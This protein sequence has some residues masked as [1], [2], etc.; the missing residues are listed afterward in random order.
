MLLERQVTPPVEVEGSIVNSVHDDGLP[1]EDGHTLPS[2]AYTGMVPP[3]TQAPAQRGG[4]AT[5]AINLS[6]KYMVPKNVLNIN[7]LL[8]SIKFVEPPNL[9]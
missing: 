1:V 4:E 9:P 2:D 8:I 7:Q 6:K 5:L 3:P